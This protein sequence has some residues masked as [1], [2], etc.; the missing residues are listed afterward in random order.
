M[1]GGDNDDVMIGGAGN[2]SMG[3][4]AGNDLMQGNDGADTMVGGT[5]EDTLKGGA[6]DDSLDGGDG[7]DVLD[8][9]AG[10][11][12]IDGGV[13]DDSMR[14]GDGDDILLGGAGD[15]IIL[16]QGGDDRLEGGE[17]TDTASYS[18]DQMSYTLQI[19]TTTIELEDRRVGENGTDELIDFETLNFADGNVFDDGGGTETEFNLTKFANFATLSTDDFETFV[20]MYIAYFNRAPDAVGLYFWGT[21]LADGGLTLEQIADDF[22]TQPETMAAYPDLDDNSAFAQQ[23]Y[24]NV[25]G[26]PFDQLGLDFWVGVLDTGAVTKSQFILELLEGV[27][28]TPPSDSTTDF[29]AQKAADAQYLSDK[30]DLGIY[31]SVIKG[32]SDATNASDTLALFD[33]SAASVT[34]AKNAIDADYAD[35]LDP[36]TG[37]FLMQLVGVVDDPFMV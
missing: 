1:E 3:G 37:E 32:M 30:T 18:G 35:A 16:G 9:G 25:L 10:N 6:G 12:A 33:G 11:D 7:N 15:D 19:S 2:D 29:V 20:E 4:D 26:R 14:G 28:A 27:Y 22:F 36:T 24:Q 31:F 34:T 8:G 5:G 23:V 13:G 21:V 17:G